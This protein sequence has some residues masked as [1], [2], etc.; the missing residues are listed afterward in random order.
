MLFLTEAVRFFDYEYE[1]EHDGVETM[2]AKT[3]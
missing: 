2:R 1:H 3:G